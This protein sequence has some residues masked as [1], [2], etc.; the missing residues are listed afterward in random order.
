MVLKDVLTVNSVYN[1]CYHI[2]T[3]HWNLTWKRDKCE[4]F[5]GWGD[6][7]MDLEEINNSNATT[8]GCRISRGSGR[9]RPGNVF[10]V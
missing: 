10:L 6:V 9:R 2:H 8:A 5:Y 4:V 1:T 3:D 7:P